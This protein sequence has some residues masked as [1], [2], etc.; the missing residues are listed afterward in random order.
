MKKLA[1]GFVLSAA[2]AL[3]AAR[4][5]AA[6]TLPA[7]YTEVEYIQ[8][9]GSDTRIVT[10]YTP[11]PN[12]DK[13]EAVVS[14]PTL[15]KTMTIW[16]A[17]GS[18]TTTAS[19]TMFMINDS[20]YKLRLDYGSVNNKY[21]APTL[22][23]NT[24]YMVT[25][26]GNVGTWTNGTGV[27]HTK[28]ADF[29]AGGPVTLFASYVNGTGNSVDNW[30]KHR[31][32]SFKVWRSDALIHYF[33]PCKDANNAATLVDICDNPATLTKSGTFTAGQA[34][35][36][37][38]DTA[39][40]SL[41]ILPIPVQK[42]TPDVT[43][44]PG[45]TITNT[46]TGAN[47]T[48]AQGGVAPAGCPFDAAYSRV[49]DVGVVT[50]T[51]KAGGDY[52]GVTIWSSY[53]ASS[54]M[55]VNGDFEAGVRSPWTGGSIGDSNS[56]YSPNL[57][58]T[59][60]S[61]TY[62]GIIQRPNSMTQVF[63]NDAPCFA[64]LSW[65]CKR[66]TNNN[67]PVYYTVTIDGNVVWGEEK[68]TGNEIWFRKVDNI[69]LGAGEHTLVFQVRTDNNEDSTLFIDDVSLRNMGTTVKELLVNGDFEFGKNDPWTGGHINAA[70]GGYEPNYDTTFVSGNYCAV[71]QK[72]ENKTQVFTNSAP[73]IAKL[74]WKCKHRTNYF[75]A[76]P[77]YYT[78]TIDG[79]LVWGE[80]K[81]TG[82]T[83]LYQTVEGIKLAPGAHTLVFQG[84]TDDNQ[85][86]SLFLD[87][88]S[89]WVTR[90]ISGFSIIVR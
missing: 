8:G 67:Y 76:N 18:S 75:A 47:W 44:E 49:G 39:F 1:F 60:I 24:K 88:I 53:S 58:T 11:Q 62:C 52:V 26:E 23:A 68:F 90:K 27:T 54:E 73:C 78:V 55:L 15:D 20:G 19:W 66:R 6:G 72:S 29:T 7:G 5:W 12:T 81:V 46:A 69:K 38:D 70:T 40:G 57:N 13:I 42:C 32:Y 89:L 86:S 51:G 25:A 80:E 48:F 63:T 45:F 56:P 22:S 31:L 2:V 4:G 3:C 21:F 14:F 79:N 36:Y 33:V 34:G 82:S 10:D 9:N 65:K 59:F 17:R 84:R 87:D 28:V 85:D 16:C 50:V 43:P 64:K 35:H 37:Y 71:I 83:V 30:G 61:G 41:T 74:S 77:M